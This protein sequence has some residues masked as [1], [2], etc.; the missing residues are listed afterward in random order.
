[1]DAQKGSMNEMFS[2]PY[3]QIANTFYYEG[4]SMDEETVGEIK[5]LIPNVE[6]YRFEIS[7][8]I[9]SGGTAAWNKK[10]LLKLYGKLFVKYPMHYI[11]GFLRVTQ[12]YWYID[13]I[14]NSRIYGED[15]EERQGYLLTDTKPGYEVYHT[16]YNKPLET[17]YEKLFSANEYRNYPIVSCVFSLAIYF[18]LIVFATIHGILHKKWSISMPF[19]LTWGLILT[20]F[21]GPCALVRYAFPYIA[22]TPLLLTV[23]F[24]SE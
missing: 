19:V 15:P 4:E 9:K 16:S 1:M 11:E 20:I 5:R 12:G 7:D 21:M 3:Q 23:S 17:L 18:W 6:E 14:T 2:V 13:D 24:R 8:P 22:V 10:S